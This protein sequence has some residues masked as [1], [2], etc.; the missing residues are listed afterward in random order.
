MRHWTFFYIHAGRAQGTVIRHSTFFLIHLLNPRYSAI[1]TKTCLLFLL[2]DRR[3]A[4]TIKNVQNQPFYR[5]GTV[6][7]QRE[8]WTVS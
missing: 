5:D 4:R 8:A 3:K 1:D 6:I 7:S 2:A